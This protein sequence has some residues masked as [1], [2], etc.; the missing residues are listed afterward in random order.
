MRF[1]RAALLVLSTLS[2]CAASDFGF[3]D[4]PGRSNF[5]PSGAFGAYLAGRAAVQRSDLDVAADKLETAAKDSGVREV[6]AQAFIAAVMAGRSDAPKLAAE[7]PDN[8]VAQLV[9]AD[10][11][12]K[13]GR[14]NDAEAR[15]AGLAPSALTQVLRP[16]LVAWAQAGGSRTEAALAT[17]QPHL[18]QGRFRGV[19]ALH[20]ALIADLGGNTAAAGRLYQ[21]AQAELG[22][23]NLRLGTVLASWQARQGNLAEAQRLIR[24]MASSNGELAMA[25]L[26]LEAN[27]A[28]TAVRTAADG[29]AE[30]Y[31]AMAATLRQQNAADTAQVLLRLALAMRP[32]FTPARL[33]LSEMQE[34]A[35]RGQ[36]ALDTLDEVSS[37]DPLI[38]V[39]RLRRAAIEGGLGETDAAI[40]HLEELARAYPDRSEPLTLAGDLLRRKSRFADAVALYDRAIARVGSPSRAAWPLFYERG[41]AHERAGNWPAAESDFEFALR[42][43]P[44]HPSVLNY[45]GYAWTERN[46]RL[47]QA[48]A[49]IQRAVDQRPNEGAFIDSLGWVQLK[50]G[51]RAEALKNLEKAVELQPEDPV[52]NGHLGDALAAAGRWREAEF[53]WRRALSLKPEPEETQRITERLNTLP[54][55]AHVV[56]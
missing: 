10:T 13:A 52:V 19:S 16:L 39:V 53:Q 38:A 6:F 42:L 18:E 34:A 43:A 51:D 46:T 27:A 37:R 7:L 32:D 56:R 11:D 55:A 21:Q 40:G 24:D 54:A 28:Q 36:A 4:A 12:A 20:G 14:W 35:K 9:L 44:D 49:M 15:F 45:L 17:L 22:P 41:I 8:P 29:I 1:S 2:A 33:L 23:T 26:A 50:Q 48:R 31:L 3:D 30:T 25:R 47:D 5:K